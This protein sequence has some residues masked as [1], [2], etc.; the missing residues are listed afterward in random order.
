MVDNAQ[1]VLIAEAL[2]EFTELV[3][4]RLQM[5]EVV[6]DLCHKTMDAA[7]EGELAEIGAAAVEE[8]GMLEHDG[9]LCVRIS[10]SVAQGSVID[11]LQGR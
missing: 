4:H 10:A 3:L 11:G 9:D 5:I 6:V 1:Q 2:W 7:L 8:M